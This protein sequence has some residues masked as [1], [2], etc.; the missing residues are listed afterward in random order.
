MTAAGLS[1]V[2][3]TSLAILLALG[4]QGYAQPPQAAEPIVLRHALVMPRVGQYGRTLLH[5]DAIEALLVSGRWK[6]PTVGD[7]VQ[8]PD[9]TAVAW[10]KAVAGKDDRLKHRA[11]NGGYALWLVTSQVQRV[12]ILEANGHGVAYV[13]GE[14]R[15]G[16]LYQTGY[17]RLPVLLKAGTNEILFHCVRGQ[18]NARLL[19][20]SGSAQFNPD[21]QRLP[22]LIVGEDRESWGTIVVL[23]AGTAALEG[24]ILQLKGD[25][26]APTSTPVPPLPPLG[27]RKVAFRVAGK[28]EQPGDLAGELVLSNRGGEPLA[29]TKVR[30]RVRRPTESYVRTFRS[31]I[32]DSVQYYAVN[33]AQPLTKDGPPSALFLTL[34]GAS[35]E[36]TGQADSYYAKTW[37]HV[38]APTN[39]RPYGFDWE[40][41]GRLDALEVLDHAQKALRTDPQRTYL[42]GHS[43]GGHGVWH[44]G[45][46]YPDRFAALGP[47]A[48]WPTFWTYLGGKRAEPGTAVGKLLQRA[49]NPSD[50]LTLAPNCAG[51]GV[52]ILHGDADD[53]VPVG[54]ARLMRRRL[55][56]FHHDFVYHERP[57]AGHWW[58]DDP[59]EPGV[60]CVDWAPMFDLFA[61][62]VI[63]RPEAVR[64]VRF[65]TASPGI[66]ARSQW[67]TIAA[68]VHP[69]QFSGVQIR[70][71]PGLRRFAGTTENVAWLALDLDHVAP[72]KDLT[73]ELDG[74]GLAGI[75][76]K[77]GTGPLWISRQG[78][79]WGVTLPPPPAD[80]K[81]PHRYGPFR[82]AF[83]NHMVFVYGTRGSAAEN[84]WAL[85]KARFDAETFWYR[86]NGSVDVVPDTAFDASRERD[87]N[88]ILYGNA[89]SNAA[90]RELLKVSPVQV[91]GGEIVVGGGPGGDGRKLKG[92]NLACL[93]VRPR[94]GS[95]VASVGVVAGSGLPGMRL[96]DRLPV[97]VSGVGYPDCLVLGSETLSQGEAGV[98]GAG[99]FGLDWS[100]EG[101]EFAWK[102]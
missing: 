91:R 64:E 4:R 95:A 92:D 73:V 41:W 28:A 18:L 47:S 43:M 33:P 2:L 3:P 83:R 20:A 38:V 96:T 87:R 54:Q 27:I 61:R 13:N 31:T 86:G 67:V 57:K 6:T 51:L 19:P 9:G 32:D 77:R 69:L 48:G 37:G 39:R 100:V 25:R 59:N 84:T 36:A 21:D 62:R 74:Q 16:D 1:R 40:D 11:L 72:S 5:R 60:G 24:L 12:A 89:D 90:W 30:V 85:A 7:K 80:H 44:V 22:D 53:N 42:T 45:L 29:R 98:R 68:Q 35:V 52:Y 79:K 70:F 71:D 46:T 65:L 101:G 63:P 75:P 26:L 10:E 49:N 88:V 78:G 102:E 56:E 93:F 97:F 34:H 17:V 76:W 58:D 82:D 55:A 15:I 66:S 99:Y 94:P 23:N 50:T 8:L 81:G 14:P